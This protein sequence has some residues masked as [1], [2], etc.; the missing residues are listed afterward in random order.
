VVIRANHVQVFAQRLALALDDRTGAASAFRTALEVWRVLG[1][2]VDI[3]ECL[4]GVAAVVVDG[5]PRRA[6]QLLGSAE[7]LRQRSGVPIAAVERWRYAELVS[8]V[9]SHLR[10]DTF[11]AAWHEGRCLSMD[12]ASLKHTDLVVGLDVHDWEKQLTELNNAKRIR[13]TLTPPHC[14]FVEIGFAEIGIS[15]WSFDY[16]R[17]QPCSVRAIT[18]AKA[19]PSAPVM[20]HLSPS[21]TQPSPSREARVRS[22]DGSEPAPGDGSVIEN[23]ER[24]SPASSG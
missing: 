21:R 16:C 18:M 7:A 3:T 13:E 20:Y 6:A 17:M 1:N 4:E 8:R 19:A 15:K 22:M 12:K 2:T 23:D 14:D 24:I 5:Q 10:D 11:A 9:R